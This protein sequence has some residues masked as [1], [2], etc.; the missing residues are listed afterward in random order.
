MPPPHEL[1]SPTCS[2]AVATRPQ[3]TPCQTVPHL[4]ATFLT[5]IA[6][7]YSRSVHPPL[8]YADQRATYKSYLCRG[9]NRMRNGQL[10]RGFGSWQGMFDERGPMTRAAAFNGRRSC[11][12][13]WRTW[14]GVADGGLHTERRVRQALAR[15]LNKHLTRGWTTWG[16]YAEDR[17]A[18]LGALSR[19]AMAFSH[20]K[21]FIVFAYLRANAEAA[22][23]AAR[24]LVVMLPEGR[25][26]AWALSQLRAGGEMHCKMLRA[27]GRLIARDA[28]RT[29]ALWAAKTESRHKLR[30]FLLHTFLR[31][32][33]RGLNG[34]AEYARLRKLA[35][36]V[37]RHAGE[38][39]LRRG[40]NGWTSS[41]LAR[42]TAL[43][44]A[45]HA[46]SRR[47]HT[48]LSN[49]FRLWSG[50]AR[51]L[52]DSDASA[53]LMRA[54]IV[55]RRLFDAIERWCVARWR[56]AVASHVASPAPWTT[57]TCCRS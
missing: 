10:S 39:G 42:T 51:S 7:L 20:H 27:G 18:S 8:S 45:G 43:E 35:N 28:S 36:E 11:G 13:A 38:Q 25:A 17:L 49:C 16:A 15:M 34:W 37:L 19:G 5:A 4:L 1:K 56:R 55:R 14:S 32:A 9:L 21:L 6:G 48:A 26:M 54:R 23:R 47:R 40:W 57:H 12:R 50:E 22:A 29:L 31:D 2:G 52:S 3:S 30:R 41:A 53:R 46:F 24:A 33:S 44:G